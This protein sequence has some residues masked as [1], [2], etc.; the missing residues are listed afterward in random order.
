MFIRRYQWKRVRH[1]VDRA[2]IMN[3]ATGE[4]AA[5]VSEGR[6]AREILG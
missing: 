2:T 3:T 1:C 6:D 5:F 4:Q